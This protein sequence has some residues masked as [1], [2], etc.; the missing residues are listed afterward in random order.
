MIDLRIEVMKAI[1]HESLIDTKDMTRDHQGLLIDRT[2]TEKE[3]SRITGIESRDMDHR[4]TRITRNIGMNLHNS[5]HRTIFAQNVRAS[6][7]QILTLAYYVDGK[8]PMKRRRGALLIDML[9]L[10]GEPGQ[11][12][13]LQDKGQEESGP[14]G[15]KTRL[16][17]ARIVEIQR[18]NSLQM[19]SVD[20]LH[21]C[22]DSGSQAGL[23]VAR[24]SIAMI[25][26][27]AR[28]ATIRTSNST[29]TA[30]A[31]ARDVTTGSDG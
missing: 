31:D 12:L 3:N 19:G 25:N 5:N 1:P 18:F 4:I 21:V 29:R 28:N 2:V 10:A 6:S 24:R 16:T 27:Y 7:L 26:T 8:N 20:V 11:Q 23:Q 22:I 30:S 14:P 9:A 17:C 13:P 15:I